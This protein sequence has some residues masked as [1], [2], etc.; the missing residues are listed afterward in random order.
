MTEPTRDEALAKLAKFG[1]KIGY[2]SKWRDVSA[3]AIGR[4]SFVGNRLAASAFEHTTPWASS[5]SPWIGR[6]GRCRPTS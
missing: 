4:D 2:P 3:L 5:A 1:W 6:S